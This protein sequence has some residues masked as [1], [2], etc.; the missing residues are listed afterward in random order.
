MPTIFKKKKK[1]EKS[2]IIKNTRDDFGFDQDHSF[3][4][5]SDPSNEVFSA[6]LRIVSVEREELD[7]MS[8]AELEEMHSEWCY[9]LSQVVL[10]SDIAGISFETQEDV[11][12][13]FAAPEIDQQFIT[14]VISHYLVW[15]LDQMGKLK[16]TIKSG[17]KTES[18]GQ[19]E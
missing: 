2:Y 7:E 13:A 9:A 12:A 6:L 10:D 18:S 5:W 17:S 4:L 14:L 1:F 16:K 15:V 19:N 11:E 8:E 3:A